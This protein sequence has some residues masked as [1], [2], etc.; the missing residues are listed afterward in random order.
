MFH[1]RG[2]ITLAYSTLQRMK[3]IKKSYFLGN[4]HPNSKNRGQIAKTPR[5]TTVKLPQTHPKR[6]VSLKIF[7]FLFSNLLRPC[8]TKRHHL[9]QWKKCLADPTNQRI[10]VQILRIHLL[11]A[12]RSHGILRWPLPPSCLITLPR[13][14]RRMSLCDRRLQPATFPVSIT[15]AN[16]ETFEQPKE[17]KA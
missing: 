17:Q 7:A 2:G 13:L 5:I 15:S 10:H 12:R 1:W 3:A 16:G 8:A 4:A 6:I 9:K 14:H 11:R